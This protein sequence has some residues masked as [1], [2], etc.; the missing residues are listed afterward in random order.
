MSTEFDNTGDTLAD[1]AIDWL[2][3]MRSGTVDA[4]T[5]RAFE[6]WL[7]EDAAHRQAFAEAEVLWHGAAQ[8]L[9]QSPAPAGVLTHHR[10]RS[11]RKPW[12]AGLAVA[13]SVVLSVA[14]V[15]TTLAPSLL[16]DYSTRAGEQKRVVLADGSTVL[17]N[18]D[19]AIALDWSSKQRRI[20]LLKGQAEFQVAPDAARPFVVAAGDLSVRALGTVFE[21]YEQASGAVDV[22]VSEHAVAVVLKETGGEPRRVE[23]GQRLQYAGHGPLSTA[24]AVDLHRL[25][26]WKRGKLIFR[27]RPLTEVVAELNRY[28]KARIVLQGDRVGSLRVSGVFPTDG[29]Q[30]LEALEKSFSL[31]TLHLG[32]WLVILH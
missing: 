12:H 24:A 9:G 3:R 2:V 8:A 30:V 25:N 27:D 16:G 31:R 10:P 17:L 15:W 13:A 11:A 21:V 4:N 7:Q 29:M 1:T 32:P 14:V 20:I 6:R 18:T 19:S 5:R 22:S 26:A 28:S 23:E